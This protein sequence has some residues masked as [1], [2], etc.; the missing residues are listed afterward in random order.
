MSKRLTTKLS[1]LSLLCAALIIVSCHMGP[2]RPKGVP[3]QV[4]GTISSL[5]YSR[6][7]DVDGFVLNTG[8]VVLVGPKEAKQ[9]NVSKGDQIMVVGDVHSS[10][11]GTQVIEA[12]ELN[13]QPLRK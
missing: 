12:R 1:F 6:H 10:P 11:T 2:P 13:G 8:E 4:K 3:T 7:G 9:L 5:N